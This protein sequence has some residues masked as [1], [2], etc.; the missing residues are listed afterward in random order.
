MRSAWATWDTKEFSEDNQG[1]VFNGKYFI[2][3]ARLHQPHRLHQHNE[4]MKVNIFR[5][6]VYVSGACKST[7][8]VC[9]CYNI[10]PSTRYDFR[11]ARFIWINFELNYFSLYLYARASIPQKHF[12]KCFLCVQL[13]LMLPKTKIPC[14]VWINFAHMRFAR[15]QQMKR[16]KVRRNWLDFIQQRTFVS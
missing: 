7:M 1:A 6:S 14:H 5:G 3:C 2:A 12:E 8:C 16:R 11:R 15:S 13:K 4:K 9:E 10:I